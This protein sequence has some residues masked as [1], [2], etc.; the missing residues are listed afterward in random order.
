MTFIKAP[1]YSLAPLLAGSDCQFHSRKPCF[2]Y[3]L[4]CFDGV[5]AVWAVKS[6][7]RVTSGI[8]GRMRAVK[9]LLYSMNREKKTR[10]RMREKILS[11]QL[12]RPEVSLSL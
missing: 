10:A 9:A 12:S 7:V 3:V 11:A 4:T 6:D 2:P 1:D 8:E 5:S